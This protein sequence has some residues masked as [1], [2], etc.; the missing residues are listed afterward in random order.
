MQL[1]KKMARIG[2]ESAFE[3]LVKARAL[4]AEGKSVYDKVAVVLTDL[5]M[6]EMDGFTLTR[7][8][9]IH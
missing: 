2:V 4:E 3:V 8:I 9:K 6:P 1:V 7:N 5:E